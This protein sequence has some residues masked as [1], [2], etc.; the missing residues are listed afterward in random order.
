MG[1]WLWPTVETTWSLTVCIP[2]CVC[3]LF[4]PWKRV[5]VQISWRYYFPFTFLCNQIL[6]SSK[7]KSLQATPDV[8]KEVNVDCSVSQHLNVLFSWVLMAV[9]IRTLVRREILIKMLVNSD[10]SNVANIKIFTACIYWCCSCSGI[11]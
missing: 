5:L 1:S 7:R 10:G 2:D 8:A 3:I 6:S 4:S 9:G 11:H